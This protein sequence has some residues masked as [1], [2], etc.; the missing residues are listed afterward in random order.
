[1]RAWRLRL[2][3]G[4]DR[5]SGGGTRGDASPV[6]GDHHHPI[7]CCGGL[8]R[9]H[10]DRIVVRLRGVPHEDGRG[11]AALALLLLLLLLLAA[12]QLLGAGQPAPVEVVSAAAHMLPTSSLP[13]AVAGVTAQLLRR[14]QLAMTD[15]IADQR[16]YVVSACLLL[17]A[18]GQP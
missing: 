3:R 18:P 11:L 2:L 4:Q 15:N 10:G 7:I 13:L 14:P 8:A 5:G 1:R 12:Q 6:N 17:V 16:R 9:I